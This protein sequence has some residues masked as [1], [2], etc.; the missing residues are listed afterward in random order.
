MYPW[1]KWAT[2]HTCATYSNIIIVGTFRLSQYCLIQTTNISIIIII[3]NT[4]WTVQSVYKY[5]TSSRWKGIWSR[6][7]FFSIYERK[8]AL[9]V[10]NPRCYQEVN[11]LHVCY[12]YSSHGQTCTAHSVY[13]LKISKPTLS[14]IISSS[15]LHIVIL[16]ATKHAIY[17]TSNLKSWHLTSWEWLYV[18]MYICIVKYNLEE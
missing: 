15:P 18:H 11:T 7:Q 6:F 12:I 16:V 1:R 3:G 2:M 8:N 5:R 13:H 10:Q 17:R 9:K 14:S 4:R